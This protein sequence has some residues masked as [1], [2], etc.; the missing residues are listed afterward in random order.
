MAK[1]EGVNLPPPALMRRG[2]ARP[3]GGAG[4]RPLMG[5]GKKEG[6]GVYSNDVPVDDTTNP[7]GGAA[8][9]AVS[10]AVEG[11]RKEPL[12]PPSGHGAAK[13]KAGLFLQLHWSLWEKLDVLR[14]REDDK[15]SRQEMVRRLIDRVKV[16]PSDA[17][18]KP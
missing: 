5:R 18:V 13:A 3:A 4:P 12:P 1:V 14:F 2:M 17:V 10:P 11:D 7:E 6:G 15:P 8:C 16:R 9:A